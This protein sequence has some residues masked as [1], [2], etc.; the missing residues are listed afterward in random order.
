M[1]ADLA[2]QLHGQISVAPESD[3]CRSE[4]ALAGPTFELSLLV[5][6]AAQV[7]EFSSIHQ[8]IDAVAFEALPQPAGLRSRVFYI[9]RKGSSETSYQL[10]FTYDDD[11]TETLSDCTGMLIREVSS[12]NPLKLVEI[13]GSGDF[14]WLLAGW[15][16]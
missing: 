11:S 4:S 14:E 1:A 12:S 16:A 3:R 2:I 15:L 13:I 9:R 7:D 5:K 10:R 6:N 8:T